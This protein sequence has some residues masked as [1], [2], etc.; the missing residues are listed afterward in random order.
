[1]VDAASSSFSS[2]N[3]SP[4]QAPNRPLPPTPDDDA[5]GERTLITRRHKDRSANGNGGLVNDLSNNGSQPNMMNMFGGPASSRVSSVLPDLLP[6]PR[7]LDDKNG[8]TVEVS[9]LMQQYRQEAAA[10]GTPY[11]QQKQRSFLTFGFGAGGN[12]SG[13]SLSPN[14]LG[15]TASPSPRRESQVNVNVPAMTQVG[16]SR[17]DCE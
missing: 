15:P 5:D 13:G 8:V 17:E 9:Q 6:Q 10:K 16:T 11:M 2:S 3:G 1:M 4:S 14:H 12:G 7:P